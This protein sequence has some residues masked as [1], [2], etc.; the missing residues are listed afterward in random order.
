MI[1]KTII[2]S[3]IDNTQKFIYI[4]D[5]NQIVEIAFIDKDD[6]KHIFCVPTQTNCA[7]GCRFC[8]TR[9]VAGKVPVIN[10]QSED[11]IFGV[12]D[13]YERLHLSEKPLLISFM[14]CGEPLENIDQLCQS[15]IDLRVKFSYL[16]LVRFAIA[17]LMPKNS[18]ERFV[19]LSK[20]IKSNE[21]KVKIHLSLHFTDDTLRH[22]WM[23]MAEEI[24][25]S[26]D[27][28]AWYK[29]YTGNSVE[30]H[31][32]PIKDVNDTHSDE[33]NLIHLLKNNNIPIKF[34]KFTTRS[35][36]PYQASDNINHLTY[37]LD[38]KN[39]IKCEYYDPP[40]RDVGASCGQF[41][42]D[43]YNKYADVKK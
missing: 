23:P 12:K 10:L 9:E 4:N 31:Y 14:G 34:L 18:F 17:T 25:P 21:L 7:M 1:L 19:S 42:F 27:I 20:F 39:G 29:D 37:E 16:P 41:L 32:T 36:E 38:Y 33:V 2:K 13:A 30:I 5:A 40:G 26:I 43:Y 28:L 24:K 6:G 35:S 8:H 22:E 3:K 11:I 15:M